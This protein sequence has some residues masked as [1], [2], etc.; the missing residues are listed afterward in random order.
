MLLFRSFSSTLRLLTLAYADEDVDL[1]EVAALSDRD[2]TRATGSNVSTVS[3]WL[4]RERALGGRRAERLVELRQS[5][6][7]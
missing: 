6:S 7:G 5:P 1:R 4:W 3:A 2:I